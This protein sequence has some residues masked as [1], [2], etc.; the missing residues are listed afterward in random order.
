MGQATGTRAPLVGDQFASRFIFSR[1]LS[2]TVVSGLNLGIEDRL[3]GRPCRF[4]SKGNEA[5]STLLLRSRPRCGLRTQSPRSTRL[6]WG[7][8][9]R[10]PRV[11]P[12]IFTRTVSRARPNLD[13][14]LSRRARSRSAR[15]GSGV[16]SAAPSALGH[17]EHRPCDV[18]LTAVRVQRS[19]A[20]I[21]CR[22]M[23]PLR[24][25][26]TNGFTNWKNLP[27]DR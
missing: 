13:R 25:M 4:S 27:R 23:Q 12:G 21:H 15:S 19:F 9:H 7:T 2:A 18:T 1:R 10:R 8:H 22:R 14:A 24:T 6:P 26:T 16:P 5:R 17:R 11:R 20:R 3:G